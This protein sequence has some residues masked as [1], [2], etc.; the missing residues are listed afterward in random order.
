MEN[1]DQRT[2]IPQY[3]AGKILLVWAA[4][5]IPMGLLGWVVAPALAVHSAK[6]G[7]V[8]LGVLTV[9]LI[10]Q[11]V[12]ILLLLY[13]ETGTLRWSALRQRLWLQTPASPQTGQPRR[14][15]W[16]WIL[17]LILLT[18]VYELL[19]GDTLDKLWVSAFPFF[20]EPGGFSLS[21]VLA[22]P[23]GKA[24]FV[25]AWDVFGLYLVSALFNTVLGEE[26]LFRGL[27][28]PRMSGV[29]G[30]WAWA[31]NGLLFGAYH[32]HQP[33]V[34]FSAAVQGMLLLALPSRYFRSSWFGVISHS[35]QSIYF[36][37]LILGLVLG[38][39]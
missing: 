18:V 4:A 27:L 36:S 9:G 33:W 34:I 5:A 21:S 10:W 11:F 6:P 22:T 26:L 3:S 7:I 30:K 29:F 8:R 35:G 38:L 31:M 2:S 16:W 28:L 25:G 37:F 17:P 14:R 32:L 1:G 24:Q 39:A 23:A 12:L 15:L 20:A 13:R 19:V